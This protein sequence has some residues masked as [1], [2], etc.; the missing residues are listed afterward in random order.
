MVIADSMRLERCMEGDDILD[1]RGLPGC[2]SVTGRR[3]V[4]CARFLRLTVREERDSKRG[5]NLFFAR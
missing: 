3:R 4:R 5:G 2:F 1:E